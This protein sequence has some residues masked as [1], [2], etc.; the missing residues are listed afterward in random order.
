MP[1]PFQAAAGHQALFPYPKSAELGETVLM[2]DKVAA[3]I[4][5]AGRIIRCKGFF[6]VSYIPGNHQDARHQNIAIIFRG[7]LTPNSA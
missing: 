6:I 5:G 7:I 3:L 2:N 4:D 1:F